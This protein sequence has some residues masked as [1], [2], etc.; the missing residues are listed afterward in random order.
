MPHGQKSKH[1]AREKRPQAWTETQVL[2]DQATTSG[3][4]ETTSSSPPDSE[5]A[6]SSSSAAGT[7]KGRQGAQGTTSAAA[8]AIRKRSGCGGAARSR[9]GV[10]AEGQVQEGENSSQVSAAA[11]SSHTDLLTKKE[12][13]ALTGGLGRVTCPRQSSQPEQLLT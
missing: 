9:S 10:G 2:H 4:E 7:L 6:P 11:E 13:E 1:C 3:G 8:G 12:E 5:S